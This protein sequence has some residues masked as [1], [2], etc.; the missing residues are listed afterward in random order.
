M[1]KIKADK[2]TDLS[3]DYITQISRKSHSMIAAMDDMIWSI[4]P[5]ND[6]IHKTLSRMQEY[7]D[8]LRN[9]QKVD[10]KLVLDE[11]IRSKELDM[12]SRHELFM[13]FKDSLGKLVQHSTG[14]EILINID[15]GRQ[16]IFMKLHDNGV[17]TAPTDVFSDSEMLLMLKRAENIKAV[18]DIQ[19]DNKGASVILL[20]PLQPS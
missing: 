9:N 16:R 2:D 4:N 10:I 3:K 14:T 6:N 15:L 13:L 7:A 8:S 19:T 1:A 20:I 12:K 5:E 11:K 18:L 17:Y